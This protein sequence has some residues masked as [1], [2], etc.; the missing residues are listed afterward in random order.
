MRK[1]LIAVAALS[2]VIAVADVGIRHQ[3][4]HIAGLH[5]PQAPA[6][7]LPSRNRNMEPMGHMARPSAMFDAASWQSYWQR[8]M[9]GD[10]KTAFD[11]LAERGAP[12]AAKVAAELARSCGPYADHT[13]AS[14]LRRIEAGNQPASV[15]SKQKAM[16]DL[17]RRNCVGFNA[18]S[19]GLEGELEQ[20][21]SRSGD[22]HAFAFNMPG[23]GPTRELVEKAKAAAG[24]QDPIALHEV[25]AFFTRRAD[26]TA[27]TT[28]DL[29]D[30]LFVTRNIIRDSFYLAACEFGDDCGPTS[31]E[32]A[33]SCVNMGWCDAVNLGDMFVA[34]SYSPADTERLFR[35]RDVVVI[36]VR[37]GHWPQGLWQPLAYDIYSDE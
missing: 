12:F 16:A 14:T 10:R 20:R 23:E 19:V 26:A 1:R 6:V 37:T 9:T 15:K 21:A 34:Y 8:L 22:L 2:G 18:A 27:R 25:A 36:G 7:P 5:K 11:A 13:Y 31:R 3:S 17:Q 29:G 28:Y 30:G 33:A 35:T 24:L 4:A 32:V